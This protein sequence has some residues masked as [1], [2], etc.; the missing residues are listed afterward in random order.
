MRDPARFDMLV[1]LCAAIVS[2]SVMREALDRLRR[3]FGPPAAAAF[4]ALVLGLL[5][6]EYDPL[7]YPTCSAAAPA[8]I[9]LLGSMPDTRAV[10]DVP[11]T[12]DPRYMYDQTIH[13]RPILI[14]YISRAPSTAFAYVDNNA[15]LSTISGSE[16]SGFA[17]PDAP[18]DLDAS[19]RALKRDGVGYVVIHKDRCDAATVAGMKTLFSRCRFTKLSEDR[20]A[21]LYRM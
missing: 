10:I 7:P 4:S 19:I 17:G 8:P 20:D 2:A 3:R 6:L 11:L 9:R 12:A 1:L 18:P 14:G 16:H 13:H 5:L 15:F 21:V